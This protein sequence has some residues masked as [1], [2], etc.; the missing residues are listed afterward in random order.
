MLGALSRSRVRAFDVEYLY[1]QSGGSVVRLCSHQHSPDL[2]TGV[3]A[4]LC[5]AELGATDCSKENAHRWT[6]FNLKLIT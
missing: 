3:L 4:V 6:I 5:Q 2:S 1:V